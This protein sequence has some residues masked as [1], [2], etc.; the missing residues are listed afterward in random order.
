VKKILV[1]TAPLVSALDARDSA[2]EFAGPLIAQLRRQALIPTPVLAEVD[3]FVRSRVGG[4]E[5]RAFLRS[6]VGGTFNIAYLTA[7]LVRRAGELDDRYADLDLGFAD[8]CLMAIAER[9]EL[10]ILTFDFADFHATE[11]ASG[12]WRLVLDENAYR[13]ATNR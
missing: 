2:H 12:P 6:I 4:T 1:D 13:A 11:S 9:H 8:T 7:G 3:H 5:A 10:P